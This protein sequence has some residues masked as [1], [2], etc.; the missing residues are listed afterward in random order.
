ME[1]NHSQKLYGFFGSQISRE[2]AVGFCYLHKCHLTA[3]T[4][5]CKGC[6]GKQCH[7]LKKHEDN[8]YWAE[9]E[10]RKALKKARRYS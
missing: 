5:K 7:H 4:L 8:I 6:L 10:I 2:K 3:N 1:I 9:R